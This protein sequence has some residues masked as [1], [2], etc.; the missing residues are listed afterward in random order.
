[1]G[2]LGAG[3]TTVGSLL[4]QQLGWEF[5]DADSFHSAANIEKMSHGHP[6]TDADRVPWLAAIRQAMLRWI[7]E[8]R[9]VVLACSA[10][11]ESYRSLL[12]YP[13]V[14]LVYLKADY[15]LIINR[16]RWRGGHF[17][18]PQLLASQFADLEQPADAIVLDA[19]R[20]PDEIV[21]ELRTRLAH[22]T[23]QS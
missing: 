23:D 20:P 13:D 22:K 12:I 21:Q 5:V 6:L 2:A 7:A 4:A 16:L 8:H 17:A 10:L 19:S 1:M 3:K 15:D 18:G 14:K 9:N 11:K